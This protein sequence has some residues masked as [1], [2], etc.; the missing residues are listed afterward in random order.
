MPSLQKKKDCVKPV[1]YTNTEYY[2]SDVFH[3]PCIYCEKMI[4]V[5]TI[6][7]ASIS[8]ITKSEKP[9]SESDF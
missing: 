1:V 8:T 5:G 2:G 7:T 3:L 9:K 4:R 6:R